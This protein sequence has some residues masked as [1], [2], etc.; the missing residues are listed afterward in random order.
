MKEILTK[1]LEGRY[2][3]ARLDEKAVR[4]SDIE[5]V[6]WIEDLPIK[7]ALTKL[8]EALEDEKLK[9]SKLRIQ[10]ASQE[11]KIEEIKEIVVSLKS[12]II[13]KIRTSDDLFELPEEIIPANV[14]RIPNG[15]IEG[16]TDIV[17]EH[18]SKTMYTGTFKIKDIKKA[19]QARTIIVCY[20]NE[21]VVIQSKKGSDTKVDMIGEAD[22][23]GMFPYTFKAVVEPRKYNTAYLKK[24]REI[25]RRI[26]FE[27][28]QNNI[29]Q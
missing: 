11:G 8:E 13:H 28:A 24:V 19:T 14:T 16:I 5:G 6:I 26:E 17:V 4:V 25:K 1:T 9:L 27:T 2:Y 29:I 21:N 20:V 22:E 7:E 15:T 10:M 12:E 23:N 18:P 3:I